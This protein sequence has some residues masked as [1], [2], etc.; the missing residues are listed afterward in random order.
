MVLA[1][2]GL[3][4]ADAARALLHWSLDPV[5]LA[6]CVL[7]G[8][9][10]AGAVRRLRAAG[11][12]FPRSRPAAFAA[13]LI[14]VLI[15]L[16]S[17]IDVYADALFSVHMAQHLLLAYVAPP[18][19]A[20]GA[21]IT[22]AFAAS[23]PETRRRYLVPLMRSR[24]VSILAH[25]LVGWSLF[26]AA[27]FAIH[28]SPLFEAAMERSWVHVLEHVLF[29]GTGL[30]FWW[31]IVGLDPAP[32][33]MSYPA[34]LLSLTMAM[35]VTGFVAV[36][37]TSADRP[38]YGWYAALPPRWSAEALSDQRWAAAIMWVA[39]SLVLIVAGL[40]VAVAWKRHDDDRQRR[41]EAAA[42]G[43]AG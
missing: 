3:P 43:S 12:P 34:R 33:R 29:L 26:V 23:R 21:P 18:L 2:T 42:D 19:L 15:A 6:G 22:L 10:Y 31:P 11:R 8:L 27:S 36:A 17:P 32:H 40:L 7:V 4:P 39:G 41:I 5:P 13:G 38:L 24:P 16:V 1:A 14:V 35:V 30:L 28:F 37:I 25:P 20:L 9:L